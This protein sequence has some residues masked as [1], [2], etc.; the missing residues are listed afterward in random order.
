V[1]EILANGADNSTLYL[2]VKHIIQ[3]HISS[4]LS[5]NYCNACLLTGEQLQLSFY[6]NY[7]ITKIPNLKVNSDE[8]CTFKP[9][10]LSV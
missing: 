3:I 8:T 4:R 6:G 2:Y 1:L 7:T 10:I 9:I 5:S